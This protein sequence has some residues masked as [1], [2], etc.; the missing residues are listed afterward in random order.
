MSRFYFVV[1]LGFCFLAAN[2][3]KERSFQIWNQN[4]FEI[5]LSKN[6]WIKFSEKIHYTPWNQNLDLKFA[7]VFLAGELNHWLELGGGYRIAGINRDYGWLKEQRSM[8]Y[9]NIFRESRKLEITFS[10][11]FEYRVFD[12]AQ[13]HFRHKQ[14]LT[15]EFPTLS[16]WNLRFYVAEETFQKF[17]S[18]NLHLARFYAGMQLFEFEHLQMKM[19]YIFEKFKN[20]NLW[21]TRNIAGI[22]LSVEI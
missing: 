11:R 3:Q 1:F 14:K 6:T 18:Q 15:L 5:A 13:N 20:N 10:N 7:D 2:A 16:V 21:N 4:S 8:I 17:T 22:N 12:K 9:G 19:Y